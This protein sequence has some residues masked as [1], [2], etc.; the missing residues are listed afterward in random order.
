MAHHTTR[1][2]RC[3]V[4]TLPVLALTVAGLAMLS[5]NRHHTRATMWLLG[6]IIVVDI[7]IIGSL[8]G[9]DRVVE[10]I[11]AGE[12]LA[13]LPDLVP[14]HRGDEEG[15]HHPDRLSCWSWCSASS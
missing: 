14:V 6:S 13:E 15:P 2:A 12:Q 4:A 1:V 5:L 3:T 7:A 10:R 9:A 8:I 11:E